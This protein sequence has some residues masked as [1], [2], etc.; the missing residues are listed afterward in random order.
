MDK[1]DWTTKE[2]E[3]LKR[4]KDAMVEKER[5]DILKGNSTK[6]IGVDL[7][8]ENSDNTIISMTFLNT[9]LDEMKEIW[10]IGDEYLL[11]EFH[12]KRLGLREND[13]LIISAIY[14]NNNEDVM[15][16]MLVR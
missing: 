6:I 12:R 15:M 4:Q 14:E 5:L 10:K 3:D 2:Y 11:T 7:A 9:C 13:K 8:K 16:N 1:N